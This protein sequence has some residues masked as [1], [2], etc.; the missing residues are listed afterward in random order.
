MLEKI[1]FATSESAPE[2]LSTIILESSDE[3]S[4]VEENKEVS[5]QKEETIIKE[6]QKDVATVSIL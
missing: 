6:E 4:K 2:K 5:G 1:E 3:I